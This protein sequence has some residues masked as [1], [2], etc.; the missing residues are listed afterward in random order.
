MPN[1]VIQTDDLVSISSLRSALIKSKNYSNY[2]TDK[3]AFFGIRFENNSLKFY[4]KAELDKE[5]TAA[6]VEADPTKEQ[7]APTP[8]AIVDL[9]REQF[10][11]ELDFKPSF[12]FATWNVEG[13]GAGEAKIEAEDYAGYGHGIVITEGED[14]DPD[15][16]NLDG[17]P[18]LIFKYNIQNPVNDDD[19]SDG[20]VIEYTETYTFIDM[21]EIMDFHVASTAEVTAMLNE[22]FPEIA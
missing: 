19:A 14:D 16:S 8:A 7:Y 3:Q 21:S 17:L 18:V 11:D 12:N 1:P 2:Y 6:D 5:V 13:M 4:T 20:Q 22:V 9:P 15:T 10:L